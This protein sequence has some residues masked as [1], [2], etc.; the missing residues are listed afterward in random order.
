VIAPVEPTLQGRVAVV[1]GAGVRLGK[2]IA[3][4]VS[5]QGADVVVH[6]S[7]SRAGAEGTAAAVRARGSRAVL[8]QADLTDSSQVARVFSAAD[9]LGGCD[10]LVNSAAIFERAPLEAI[11]DL[12]WRR[13]LDTN[14]SAPFFCCR[15]AVSAM[16]RK[17]RGDIV[18]ILD[19]GGVFRPWKRYAHYCAAKAG[20]AMLTK[21]LAL[22]LAPEVRVNGIAPGTV[23]FPEAYGEGER[24]EVLEKIPLGRVGSPDDVTRAVLFLVSGSSFVTGQILAV[25]GG[26]SI[27]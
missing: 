12:A 8:V 5:A 2:A 21:C 16:R 26:R 22:E 25:D 4:A 17:G 3:E 1:T 9:A 18:N 15:A 19:V 10:L 6:F 14:L 24:R 20:L 27:A 7:K 23:L 11:D 13:M